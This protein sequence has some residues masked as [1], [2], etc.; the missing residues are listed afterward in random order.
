MRTAKL[1]IEQEVENLSRFGADE[2]PLIKNIREQCA[3]KFR[4]VAIDLL[5]NSDNFSLSNEFLE[6]GISFSSSESYLQQVKHDKAQLSKTY[7][8]RRIFW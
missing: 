1:A 3:I 7:N 2:Y 4:Y 8:K 6:A 5:N